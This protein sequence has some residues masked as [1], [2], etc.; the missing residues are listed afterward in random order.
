MEILYP[1]AR[2]IEDRPVFRSELHMLGFPKKAE[3]ANA[4]SIR[5]S[6]GADG[7][8]RTHDLFITS[9]LLYP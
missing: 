5:G 7:E 3:T 4:D 1:R 6:I 2:N 8:N 9:E